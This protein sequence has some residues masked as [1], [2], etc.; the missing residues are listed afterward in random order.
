MTDVQLYES[1]L[2]EIDKVKAPDIYLDSFNYFANRAITDYINLRYNLYDTKQQTTDD[3]RY[4][5]KSVNIN[6]NGSV[7]Q[8]NLVI[9]NVTV[10]KINR[11]WSYILP[12][13]YLHILKVSVYFKNC[14]E[15]FVCKKYTSDLDGGTL[16]NYYLKPKKRNPYFKI[17][18]NQI[19]IILDTNDTIDLLTI[20]YLKTPNVINL[21]DVTQ[22]NLLEFDGYVFYEI[23]KV[24]V[25]LILENN[26][27]VRLQTNIPINQVIQ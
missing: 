21:L 1:L 4:W 18:N 6:I 24:L 27:D 13:D 26:S 11:G 17:N 9:G 3:L 14:N 15:T 10:N 7:T 12:T 25:K 23:I 20:D 16:N 5:F 22:P 8:N 2:Q 19:E